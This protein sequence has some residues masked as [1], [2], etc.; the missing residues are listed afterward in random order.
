M[1]VT[2]GASGQRWKVA[3]ALGLLITVAGLALRFYR[4][5]N[6]SMWTDEV[7]SIITARGPLSQMMQGSGVEN[8]FLPGYFLLLRAVL[9][10]ATQDLEFRARALSALAGALSVPLFMGVV[11]L[12]RRQWTAA[13]LAGLLLAL[14]PLHL[15]YSQ[16]VRAYGTM[17]FF[18]LLTL[19]AYELARLSR[20]WWWWWLLPQLAR[21]R[22]N[23]EM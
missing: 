3:V 19:L 21:L 2:T 5:P 23:Q 1:I 6:Q 15:W 20:K 18:C 11:Y 10:D 8:V 22:T 17:L 9:G 12:W 13:L 14:N 7:S 4:L 16:E